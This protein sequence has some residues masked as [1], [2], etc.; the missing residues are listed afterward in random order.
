MKLRC[1]LAV[2]V[3]LVAGISGVHAQPEPV[4]DGATYV[5]GG[6]L[7]H[8]QVSPDGK[9]L[10]GLVRAMAGRRGLVARNVDGSEQ[11]VVY[12]L[13]EPGMNLDL[14]R[15]LGNEHLLLRLSN[16]QALVQ[17]V[18]PLPITR[19]VVLGLDGKP[20]QVLN[21]P[22]HLGWA[23]H[24]SREVTPACP[25]TPLVQLPGVEQDSRSATLGR[26]DTTTMRW[27]SAPTIPSDSVGMFADAQGT[28]G[29]IKRRSS[30][31]EPSYVTYKEGVLSRWTPWKPAALEAAKDVRELGLSADGQHA[32]F[33]VQRED[34]DTDVWR[35][36]LAAS[37]AAPQR[38]M[39]IPGPVRTF[40]VLRNGQTCEAVGLRVKGKTWAWGDGLDRLLAGIEAQIPGQDVEMVAWQGD[41][42]VVRVGNATTP[43][44]YLVGT[45]S[46]QQLQG[47]GGTHTR[48][49][50]DLPLRQRVLTLPNGGES[51]SV[52]SAASVKGPQPTVLCID[53]DLHH[54]DQQG[55]F[56]A[57]RAYW[58]MQGWS[59]V[60]VRDWTTKLVDTFRQTGQ[61]QTRLRAI[62]EALI[63]QGETQRGQVVAVGLSSEAGRRALLLGAERDSLVQGV[64]TLGAV[65]DLP[66]YLGHT[67][68][69]LPL[70]K[71]SVAVREQLGKGLG[72]EA[73][74]QYSPI[75]QAAELK[76][77][78]LLIHADH[79]GAIHVDQAVRMHKALQ[80]HQ[81]PST[82]LVLKDSTEQIDHPPYRLEVMQA[83]DR[84]LTSV[85]TAN[86]A[87]PAGR[88]NG[89]P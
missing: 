81:R 56:H 4:V 59:V 77:A 18:A 27:L 37:D 75:H 32:E 42:Y 78:V 87:S 1:A 45:R 58:A 82:L 8:V 66:D 14:V 49:P 5:I 30:D 23:N 83:I 60:T 15:W 72:T 3:G 53:C 65:T 71:G 50:V 29:L 19:L 67:Y 89:Q 88:L 62:V 6:G 73:L 16:N 13:S 34:G 20:A 24:L 74:R 40:E 44:Q 86:A 39:R 12:H 63:N 11:R 85:R 51:V 70:G 41:R 46:T 10:A 21:R 2:C 47:L 52:L 54:E 79:D 76:A 26:F 69:G 35:L 43:T 9:R 61:N 64:V 17:G 33:V 36:P 22:R 55:S 57:L 68:S 31:G 28:V 7:E 25:G 38:L 80:S 48:L 84:M